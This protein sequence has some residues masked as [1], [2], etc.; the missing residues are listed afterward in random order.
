MTSAGR[1]S[2]YKRAYKEAHNDGLRR[3]KRKPQVNTKY[4]E[5]F[6]YE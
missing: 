6:D 5:G 1:K 3:P 4:Y 2:A